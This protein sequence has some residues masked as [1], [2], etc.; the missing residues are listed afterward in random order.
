MSRHYSC[1]MLNQGSWVLA[2]VANV[3]LSNDLYTITNGLHASRRTILYMIV[4]IVQLLNRSNFGLYRCNIINR[5]MYSTPTSDLLN[6]HTGDHGG[7]HSN[8]I[9]R[10]NFDLDQFFS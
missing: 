10:L 4:I 5:T 6:F 2:R 3:A 7:R 8:L 9:F 1:T